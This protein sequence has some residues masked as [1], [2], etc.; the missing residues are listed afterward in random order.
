[1]GK[2]YYMIDQVDF[3]PGKRSITFRNDRNAVFGIT[4]LSFSETLD[5]VAEAGHTY[6]LEI[7]EKDEKFYFWIFD[8]DTEEIVSGTQRWSPNF[9]QG[10]K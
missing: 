9:R 5:F 6:K 2:P 7:D 4:I 10:G 3:L 8:E 1:M